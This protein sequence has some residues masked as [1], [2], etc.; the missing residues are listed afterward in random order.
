MMRV[1]KVPAHAGALLDPDATLWQQV[2]EEPIRLE[3]TPLVLV[4]ELSPFLALSDDHGRVDRLGVAAAHDGTRIAFRLTWAV[5]EPRERPRDLDQFRDGVAILFPLTAG[6]AAVTMGSAGNPTNAWH[7]KAGEPQ[8]YDV[9]AEGF[10]TSQRR[11]AGDS[12]LTVNARYGAGRWC[13]VFCRPL[14][15]GRN[16][17]QFAAGGSG[18]IAFAVWS[19]ANAERSGRKSFSGEFMPFSIAG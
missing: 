4:K 14:A 8:P 1:V 19:G 3:P 10:G 13:V 11:K 12:E 18:R 6:A 5:D 15:A 9:V 17:V 7:W 2:R 16:R